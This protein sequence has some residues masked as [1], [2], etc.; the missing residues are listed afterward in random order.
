MD[1]VSPDN[2]K[3]CRPRIARM[4]AL[5]FTKMFSHGY[6]PVNMLSVQLVPL[7]K[8]KSGLIGSKDNYRPIAIASVL[9]KVLIILDRIELF[10]YTH[11]NQFGFKK[12]H[13][14]DTCIFK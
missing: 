13:G 9:T 7:I 6:L 2:L 12:Q 1:N 11:E 10:V 3:Y 4:L 5:Y 8:S 14:T